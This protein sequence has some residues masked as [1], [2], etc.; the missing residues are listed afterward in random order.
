MILFKLADDEEGAVAPD[1]TRQLHHIVGKTGS[2]VTADWQPVFRVI[3][4]GK[5]WPRRNVAAII[6]VTQNEF[7]RFDQMNRIGVAQA[8]IGA[9]NDRLRRAIDK[10]EGLNAFALVRR[11]GVQLC[12]STDGVPKAFGDCSDLCDQLIG[13][14][15]IGAIDQQGCIIRTVLAP[16]PWLVRIG[17]IIA[18]N[19]GAAGAGHSIQ[20]R[21]RKSFERMCGEPGFGERTGAKGKCQHCLAF[22]PAPIIERDLRPDVAQPTACCGRVLIEIN[23]Q[24]CAKRHKA[25]AAKHQTLNLV[26]FQFRCGPNGGAE[27]GQPGDGLFFRHRRGKATPDGGIDTDIISGQ[28][29]IS[30]V[31]E[32]GRH[33]AATGKAFEHF[34][35][36]R[37]FLK[38]IFRTRKADRVRPDSGKP[39]MRFGDEVFQIAFPTA[40]KV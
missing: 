24:Q 27:L 4:R 25:K 40:A 21:R 16:P 35:I 6:R 26:A 34:A 8:A 19:P 38:Q 32:P 10:A 22:Q 28:A 1:L 7:S 30:T 31:P 9:P 20:K 18:Q 29:G 15:L 5:C 17:G 3:Q 14:C 37:A 39:V 2:I 36:C 13:A 11:N 33:H 12:G 23:Q